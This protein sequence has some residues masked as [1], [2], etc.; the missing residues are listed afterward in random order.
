MQQGGSTRMALLACRAQLQLARQGRDL[1][2]QKRV[3][4]LQEL[5]KTVDS[6]MQE[7]NILDQS[8]SEARR[9]LAH[10]DAL[11]GAET[12]QL[13]GMSLRDEFPLQIRTMRLMGVDVPQIEQRPVSRSILG[14]GYAV[15]SMSTAVD[16]AALAFEVAIEKIIAQAESELRLKRLVDEIQRTSR[17]LN[18]LETILIPRLE[19]RAS[20]IESTLNERER[21]D[22]YRFR[23]ARRLINRKTGK[24]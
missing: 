13:A 20:M 7:S 3:A 24:R 5:F 2:D 10:A 14:R 22:H 1:L 21:E 17:R 18:A 8:L 23:L 11:A 4:L 16:S 19:H 12:V 9:A 6:I 15:T